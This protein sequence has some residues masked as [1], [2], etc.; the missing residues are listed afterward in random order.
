MKEFRTDVIE[1][2]L[3]RHE[4]RLGPTTTQHIRR[5]VQRGAEELDAYALMD[6]C[7]ELQCLPTDILRVS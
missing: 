6:M 5:L 3:E 4:S 7:R 2:L 1:Q